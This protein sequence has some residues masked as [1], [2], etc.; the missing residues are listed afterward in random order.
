MTLLS[1]WSWTSSGPQR[2]RRRA[3]QPPP[4]RLARDGPKDSASSSMSS[5]S[6]FTASPTARSGQTCSPSAR[7]TS[8]RGARQR[9]R[10]SRSARGSTCRRNRSP[11]S[12]ARWGEQPRVS[13][14][15][16]AP[17][18]ASKTGDP[19]KAARIIALRAAST[20]ARVVT[21][22]VTN[23]PRDASRSS[24]GVDESPAN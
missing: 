11:P 3:C 17:E 24:M 8:S 21:A 7:R 22:V 19:K 14:L 12:A 23:A 9:G 16:P 4:V 5:S 6:I 2:R 20:T 18:S 1:A 13:D 15:L 10:S